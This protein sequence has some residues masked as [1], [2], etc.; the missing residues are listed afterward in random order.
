M[1]SEWNERGHPWI[2]TH[3]TVLAMT[4]NILRARNDEGITL[5]LQLLYKI[6]GFLNDFRRQIS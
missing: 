1:A 3:L 6:R 2:A 5:L 4:F